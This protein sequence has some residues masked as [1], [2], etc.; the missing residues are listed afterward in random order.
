MRPAYPANEATFETLKR[1]G[2]RAIGD[3][4]VGVEN[5]LEGGNTTD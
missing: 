2:Y 1:G 3:L 5:T 4:S